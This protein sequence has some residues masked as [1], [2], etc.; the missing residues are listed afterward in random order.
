MSLQSLNLDYPKQWLNARVNN[1][2]VDNRLILPK[3]TSPVVQGAMGAT[4]PVTSE[5]GFITTAALNYAN[6]VSQQFQITC[7]TLLVNDTVLINY[8]SYTGGLPA[9]GIPYIIVAQV[10][11]GACNINIGNMGTNA[12]AGAVTFEY[13]IIHNS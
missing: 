2:W 13:L 8:R 12:M 1:I 7:P 10:L 4:V 9:N 5:H 3:N 11:N 6:G